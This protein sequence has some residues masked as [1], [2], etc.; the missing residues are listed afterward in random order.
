MIDDTQF[1]RNNFTKMIETFPGDDNPGGLNFYGMYF[2]HQIIY[3][4]KPKCVIESGVWKGGTTWLFDNI[5]GIDTII[6]IDPH[7]MKYDTKGDW[8]MYKSSK[9]KYIEKDITLINIDKYEDPAN[10]LVF[11]D[12]H[13]DQVPRLNYCSANGVKHIILDDNYKTDQGSH[14]TLYWEQNQ[15]GNVNS[16][17]KIKNQIHLNE[18]FDET[19]MFGTPKP[20]NSNITYIELE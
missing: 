1:T 3:S 8:F 11:L 2:I 17:F 20:I 9:A 4:I 19:D 5:L 18:I 12:D 13:Q 10:T 14:Q 6:C 7:V 15:L 16:K